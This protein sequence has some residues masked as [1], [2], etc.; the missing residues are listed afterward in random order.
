MASGKPGAVQYYLQAIN[1][2][3]RETSLPAGASSRSD[4]AS[5]CGTSVTRSTCWPARQTT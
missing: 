1:L 3:F 2:L 4:V 5:R